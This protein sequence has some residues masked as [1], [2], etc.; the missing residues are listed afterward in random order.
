MCLG[1]YIF[2]ERKESEAWRVEENKSN[3]SNWA[4]GEVGVVNHMSRRGGGV[5]K[6]MSR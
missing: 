3:D 1:K 4:G 6:H 5:V 2:Q